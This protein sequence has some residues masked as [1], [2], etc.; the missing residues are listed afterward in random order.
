MTDLSIT[1]ETPVDAATRAS[2][3]A[4]AMSGFSRDIGAMSAFRM[5]SCIHCGMCAEAC[6]YYIATEDPQ[7]TPIWKIEPFKQA[8]KRETS[9]FA[10]VF[11]LFDFKRAVTADQLV[12]WQHL[13]C[14]IGYYR[15][16]QL[17]LLDLGLLYLRCG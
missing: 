10:P 16:K 5:E 17:Q 1:A 6:H 8:Y 12:Q 15:R 2:Q 9:A 4:G 14:Q 13:C 11:R 7:Y 3:V